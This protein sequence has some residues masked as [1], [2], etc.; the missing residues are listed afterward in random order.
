LLAPDRRRTLFH[1]AA[2]RGRLAILQK[3]SDWANKKLTSEEINNKLLLAVD[4]RGR[5]VFHIA[6]LRGTLEIL[7]KVWECT[8]KELTTQEINIK[9]LLATYNWEKLSYCSKVCVTSFIYRLYIYIMDFY[10][11]HKVMSDFLLHGVSVS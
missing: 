9:L 7:R 6:A 8:N 2:I 4:V 5:T 11:K 1:L 10:Q 3:L